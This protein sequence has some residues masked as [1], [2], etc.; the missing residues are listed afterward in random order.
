MTRQ[1]TQ[2]PSGPTRSGYDNF[3]LIPFALIHLL[4]IY[5]F[6]V[7]F[8]TYYF[9]VIL[10]LYFG[11]M[12]F[13]TAGYH[14]YFSHRS[15]KLNRFFQFLLA[16][17]AQS[18]GQKGVLWWAAHHRLHHLNSDTAEDVH[19]P[20]RDGFLWAHVGWILS[21]KYLGFDSELIGDF[22]KFP[23]L[24]FIDRHNWV[25]PTILGTVIFLLGGWHLFLWGFAVST[26]LLY[27][28]T[29]TINSLAHLWGSRRF[30]TTD[31][32]RNNFFLAFITMGEGWHNNHHHYKH[33]CR[34]GL[35]WW[36]IDFTYYGLLM[37]SWVGVVREIRP[38][39][40]HIS[41]TE[42]EESVT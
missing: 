19:S 10:S 24:L 33:S 1:Q 20:A 29:F 6:F 38:A 28:G 34:Q 13:V 8:Q 25:P 18:S 3:Q 4:A 36:E 5:A 14:R 15:F 41:D 26:V 42:M 22:S 40:R 39:L 23:E 30:E 9:W 21:P 35:R 2:K 32:S 37:L 12:F 27:H 7:P 11:R 31:T 17:L 16:F